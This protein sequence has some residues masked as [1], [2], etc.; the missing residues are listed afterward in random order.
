MDARQSVTD[1][2][3]ELAARR[4]AWRAFDESKTR[5]RGD[6]EMLGRSL[7]WEQQAVVLLKK[8]GE[9]GRESMKRAVE[10]VLTAACQ[11]IYP[12]RECF[13]RFRE[14]R[15]LYDV[16]LRV[17][18]DGG[19]EGDPRAAS[20]GGGLCDLLSIASRVAFVNKKSPAKV[21]FIDEGMKFLGDLMTQGARFLSTCSKRMLEQI[22]MVTHERAFDMEADCVIEGESVAP[23]TCRLT[24]VREPAKDDFA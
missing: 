5:L 8:C 2:E 17:R 24:T 9:A 4:G 7:R 19:F 12:K 21:L 18:T 23:D 10:P 20:F 16:D 11:A 1:I 6:I 14:S 13:L 15:G 3:H 22:I